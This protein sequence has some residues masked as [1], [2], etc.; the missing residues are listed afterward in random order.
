MTSTSQVPP[1]YSPWMPLAWL[2]SSL[3]ALVILERWIN[4]HLQGFILLLTGNPEVVM[5]GNFL[6]LLPGIVL[7]EVSHWTSAQLLGVRT[8]GVSLLPKKKG[9]RQIHYGS[10]QI[11]P[12]DP[13]RHSLIGLAP[14]VTG[15]MAV[16]LCARFGLRIAPLSS[17]SSLDELLAYFRGPDAFLW[18]YLI[19][20]ISNAMLP[21]K[22]DRQTWGP[23][24]LYCGAIAILLLVTGVPSQISQGVARGIL[25][26]VSYLAYAFTLTVAVDLLF[27]LV[28]LILES[29]ISHLL[30]RRVQY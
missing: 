17:P 26:G 12:A 7:H 16:L 13:V 28:L 8:R 25:S 1:I 5:Y 27:A 23:V 15:S 2:V 6:F 3:I 21:S 4:R 18:L 10:I 29:V 14:L 9:A 20:A 11:G 30:G 19:F 22:S 24:L